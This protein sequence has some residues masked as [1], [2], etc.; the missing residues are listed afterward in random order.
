M[1]NYAEDTY[2]T[3]TDECQFTGRKYN[4]WHCYHCSIPLVYAI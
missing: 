2:K 1:S 4:D 3:N